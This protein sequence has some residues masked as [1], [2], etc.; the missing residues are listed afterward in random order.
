MKG[1]H[2]KPVKEGQ[3]LQTLKTAPFRTEGRARRE[4][5]SR[6]GERLQSEES[7][8]VALLAY[9][10][11]AMASAASVITRSQSPLQRI[12]GQYKSLGAFGISLEACSAAT[13]V[14]GC[15]GACGQIG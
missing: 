1:V 6:L 4:V 2:C 5:R 10:H 12:V 9:R 8:D 15:T 13:S 7:D 11:F 14:R 3:S